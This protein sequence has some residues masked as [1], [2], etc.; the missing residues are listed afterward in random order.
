MIDPGMARPAADLPAANMPTRLAANASIGAA[1]A[2]LRAE[3]GY[4]A[5]AAEQGLEGYLTLARNLPRDITEEDL[6]EAF[7]AF[8][9]VDSVSVIKDKFTGESRGFAFV[10]MPNQAGGAVRPA[11]RPRR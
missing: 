2:A 6:Q 5:L 4:E 10:E 3:L 8:G 7:G 1:R 11:H 9:K